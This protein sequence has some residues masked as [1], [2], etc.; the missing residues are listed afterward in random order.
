MP[1][2][3]DHQDVAFLE[4]DIV[5]IFFLGRNAFV[6]IVHGHG[7]NFFGAVLSDDILIEVMLDFGWLF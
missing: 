6:M 3:P 2:G 1:V 5:N 4:L 7:K